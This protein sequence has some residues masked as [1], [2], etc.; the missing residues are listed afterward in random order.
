MPRGGLFNTMKR[1][2]SLARR[3]TA[4][5]A[6][7]AG[8]PDKG[9]EGS[10]APLM[11]QHRLGTSASLDLSRNTVRRSQI[12]PEEIQNMKTAAENRNIFA[13]MFSNFIDTLK[14]KKYRNH[15]SNQLKASLTSTLQRSKS[16]PS[17]NDTDNLTLKKAA[18]NASNAGKGAS[19]LSPERDP[20]FDLSRSG[21]PSEENFVATLKRSMSRHR[22]FDPAEYMGH[23]V[24]YHD[25]L[26]LP[27]P[28]EEERA[29]LRGYRMTPSQY[30]HL[31]GILALFNGTHN[32]HNYVPGAAQDD[33]RCYIR[34]LNVE[35]SGLEQ[36]EGMEWIRI[37]VQAQSF[38][39][40]QI[41]R[42]M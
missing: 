30:D 41:R 31:R 33:P 3:A 28:S 32:W 1:G 27:I 12:P 42:M 7:D 35:A 38:A 23:E 8:L 29:T 14:G 24:T 5:S 17:G 36:H 25:P 20:T 4:R 40:Y 21:K 11:P 2:K 13:R 6:S 18:A 19:S 34:I 39:R 22:N 26:N 10:N 37:K 9:Q 16:Y 15:G